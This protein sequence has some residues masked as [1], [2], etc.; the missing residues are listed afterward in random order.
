MRFEC[1]CATEFN[2]IFGYESFSISV[3]T[4]SESGT[5]KL[6]MSVIYF[7]KPVINLGYTVTQRRLGR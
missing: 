5:T 1:Q 6:R 4:L 3:I 7:K 2:I